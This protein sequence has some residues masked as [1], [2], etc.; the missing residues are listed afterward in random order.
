MLFTVGSVLLTLGVQNLPVDRDRGI[1]MTV[2]GSLTFIPG[3]YATWILVGTLLN[4]PGYDF[5]ELPSY[6]E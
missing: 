3:A 4:W 1:A 5:S 6:D 2:I